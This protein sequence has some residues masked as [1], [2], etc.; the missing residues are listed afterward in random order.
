VAVVIA[1]PPRGDRLKNGTATLVQLG[2]N[3]IAVTCYHVL[4]EY[5]RIPGAIFQIGNVKLDPNEQLLAEQPQADLATIRLSEAQAQALTTSQGIKGDFFQP[6]SWPPAA[7]RENDCVAIG[8]YPG[9][10]R[11]RISPDVLDFYS[12]GVGA[13]AVTSVHE[14]RFA[15]Q[16]DRQRWISS[17]RDKCPN[18]EE[19]GGMSGGPVFRL[20]H[21]HW[22]LVG[23]IYEFSPQFDIMLLRPAHI[24]QADGSILWP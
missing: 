21:L 9:T 3:R 14:N 18:Q 22:E 5:R 4:E 10:W 1:E 2:C 23:F 24:I 15:C 13:T 19:L 6:R 20:G 12:Y 17:F 11:Q 8:G 16:F 7:V